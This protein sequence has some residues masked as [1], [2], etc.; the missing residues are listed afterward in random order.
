MASTSNDQV[1]TT[2][3][4]EEIQKYEYL[5]NKFNKAYKNKRINTNGW[6]KIGENFGIT[7]ED[8]ERKF[9]NMLTAD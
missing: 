9:K 3:F 7:P 1:S 5:Y 8:A 4:C 6:R 2:E